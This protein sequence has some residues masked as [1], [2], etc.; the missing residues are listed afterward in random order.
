MSSSKKQRLVWEKNTSGT[1][2]SFSTHEPSSYGYLHVLPWSH[3][4]PLFGALNY[5][6][7][8]WCDETQCLDAWS[9]SLCKLEYL[10]HL[11]QQHTIM[12]WHG[13]WVESHAFF[14]FIDDFLHYIIHLGKG[15]FCGGVWNQR[16]VVTLLDVLPTSFIDSNV[17]LRWKQ[18]KSKELGHVP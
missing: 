15:S 2:L 9:H 13:Q 11:M 3:A 12:M 16:L 18:R 8:H 1:I 14:Y 7:H 6:G 17:S 5:L 10:K 4:N